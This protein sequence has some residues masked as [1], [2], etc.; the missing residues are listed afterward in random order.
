MTKRSLPIVLFFIALLVVPTRA[1]HGMHV[2][3]LA[4]RI[5]IGS[6]SVPLFLD[7][8]TIRDVVGTD[9]L[10]GGTL[11]TIVVRGTLFLSGTVRVTHLFVLPGGT[12]NIACG[13]TLI[14]RNVPID[15]NRD[16]A[17]W[18][19]GML[20]FG[21]LNVGCQ[22]KT[23]FVHMQPAA[24][25]A[26][27]ITL[28]DDVTDWQVGDELLLPDTVQMIGT[29][30]NQ[31]APRRE[32][33]IFIASKSGRTIGLSKPLAFARA[34]MTRPDDSVVLLPYVGNLSRRATIKS[35]DPN[36][37]RW[38]V[39]FVGLAASWDVQGVALDG[40]GRT[41][42]TPLG[43]KNQIGRYAFH[44]HHVWT[45]L[46]VRRLVDSAII[47][48]G[49]GKWGVMIH[50]SHDIEVRGNIC[51]DVTGAC[52]GTEDGNEVRNVFKQN[53]GSYV[54]GTGVGTTDARSNAIANNPGAE[55]CF[56]MR[57]LGN[58]Y[59]GNVA[60]NCQSGFNLFNQLHLA[61]G[62]PIPT[63]KGASTTYT[64]NLQAMVPALFQDNVTAA[65]RDAGLEYWTVTKFPVLRQISAY[66]GFKQVWNGQADGPATIYLIDSIVTAKGGVSI[67]IA[68]SIGYNT[69]VETLRGEVRGTAIA[70]QG[71]IGKVNGDFEGTVFQ[72]T[73]DF[74]FEQGWP[75]L[76][77]A[78]T[79]HERLGA[80]P[81]TFFKTLAE[82][83]T[84]DGNGWANPKGNSP[85]LVNFQGQGKNYRL[86]PAVSSRSGLAPRSDSPWN[87][88]YPPIEC[89]TTLGEVWDT[90]GLSYGAAPYS[91]S[92]VVALEG[93][94]NMVAVPDP[95]PVNPICKAVMTSPR[96]D[97]AAQ[98]RPDYGVVIM[99][100][101]LVGD[102]A[103]ADNR[104]YFSID[105]GPRQVATNFSEN[106]A[107]A[108][109]LDETPGARQVRSWREK[110]GAEVPGAMPFHFFLGAGA[111]PP[112][113]P[114]PPP[115]PVNC[116]L[117]SATSTV[118]EWT[119]V[120]NTYTRTT[121]ETKTV[122]TEPANGGTLCQP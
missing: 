3:V 92:E 69:G 118:S 91:P 113:P 6:E 64:P 104:A 61:Q 88:A 121:T 37:V 85:R 33:G 41:T 81:L 30:N 70:V 75:P 117:S 80:D 39:A 22:A 101:A 115:G 54:T 97:F 47:G 40:L 26:T 35:E 93:L 4:D 108:W 8:P 32:T 102:P 28:D 5:A 43:V 79:R 119:K 46:N 116:A 112:P 60:M 55:S 19:N 56:W 71:G 24:A 94:V 27:S 87:W 48:R 90:C 89:G 95:R 58:V 76:T 23:A 11:D 68:S 98:K 51:V 16:P 49:I 10:D 57:G 84:S 83:N 31:V 65:N 45:S 13:T 82:P 42:A 106:F 72:N 9:T 7:L 110:N 29:G 18:G 15:L 86:V 62:V 52:F 74:P 2:E 38:H 77:F 63:A 44:M 59:D 96:A 100:F 99:M 50:Q 120:G 1:Q 34:A 78:G 111:P 17:Q 73:A 66:N 103:C 14:G 105:G 122:L 20:V 25:G 21:T 53:F 114:P 67:G 36:G 109:Y 107:W 12:L